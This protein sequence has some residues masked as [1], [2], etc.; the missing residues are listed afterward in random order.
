M[1]VYIHIYIHVYIHVYIP[2]RES[3]TGDAAAEALEDLGD[4][5]NTA[6]SHTKNCQT[7][8]R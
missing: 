1:H 5:K 6:I 3:L 4:S 7:K 2:H 8:N